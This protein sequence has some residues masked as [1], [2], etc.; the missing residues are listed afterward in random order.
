MVPMFDVNANADV[1]Q[2]YLDQFKDAVNVPGDLYV[3]LS[4]GLER[5]RE[6]ET[7]L[8]RPNCSPSLSAADGLE[9]ARPKFAVA[10]YTCTSLFEVPA[11]ADP[12]SLFIKWDML[13]YKCE[14]TGR[15]ERVNPVFSGTD[16]PD[17]KRPDS[18]EWT[19]DQ[20]WESESEDNAA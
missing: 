11:N 1:L 18:V 13:N 17:F 9:L 4:N 16:K 15:T 19:N 5:L 14:N 12:D 20:P 2:L 8:A 7:E 3:A 6:S 10:K